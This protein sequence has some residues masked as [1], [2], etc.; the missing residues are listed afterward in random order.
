LKTLAKLLPP[1]AVRIGIYVIALLAGI[2][3]VAEGRPVLE[4]WV[5]IVVGFA[6]LLALA[7]IVSRIALRGSHRSPGE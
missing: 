5:G 4:G 6:A 1:P 7:T 2:R 3:R